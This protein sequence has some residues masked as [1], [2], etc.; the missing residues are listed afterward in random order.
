[1]NTSS[2]DDR[3]PAPEH[4]LDRL[5]ALVDEV[6]FVEQL[7]RAEELIDRRRHELVRERRASV[8]S[9]RASRPVPGPD[10]VRNRD[11]DQE[12]SIR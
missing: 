10:S 7:G 3:A 1:M 8:R 11:D 9:R 6:D 2:H 5:F 12:G 4:H